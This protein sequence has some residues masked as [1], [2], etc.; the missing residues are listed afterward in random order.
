MS[1]IERGRYEALDTVE[2][3]GESDALL[4]DKSQDTANVVSSPTLPIRS[5]YKLYHLIAAFFTG[6]LAC[7][8]A[9]YAIA[10]LCTSSKS[11]SSRQEQLLAPPYAGSTEVHPFP[12]TAPTNAF[13]SLFPTG[14]GYAGATPTGAEPAI[15]VTAPA[16]PLHTGAP[17]LV[18]QSSLG[19]AKSAGTPT[20]STK[21]DIFK[22]WGNLSPWYS[23]DRTAFGLD[24]GPEAPESCRITGLHFL[25]RHGARYP[26][27]WGMS[28]FFPLQCLLNSR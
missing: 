3:H 9:Q 5:G 4:S 2:P 6:A 24:S 13:P 22:K 8:L 15:V 14:V 12:P 27:A 7:V 18:V 26:T 10:P 21:F 25:H 19:G 28:V 16:Y 20:G 23:V 11:T 1:D 17:Q